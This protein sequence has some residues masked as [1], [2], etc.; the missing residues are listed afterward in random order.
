MQ[1]M[2]AH[3]LKEAFAGESQAHMK[4]TIFADAAEKEGL[5]EVSRLF[6][7]IAYAERVHAA[8]HLR[9]LGDVGKTAD[10]LKMAEAGETYEVQQMYPA[11]NEVARMQGEKGATRST[12][13]ALEA[14]KLHIDL[15]HDAAEMVL[16]GH[17]I[18]G[19]PV[20]VCP[21]CGHTVV[22]DPPAKCPVCGEPGQ[23]FHKF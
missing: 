6:R 3:N 1:D 23:D 12:H 21:V 20:Y 13:Y 19:R 15:Y 17:D 22:G 11:F 18:Q 5:P 2:T 14:E 4:Y 8:N 7:A 16:A 10:N 9:E